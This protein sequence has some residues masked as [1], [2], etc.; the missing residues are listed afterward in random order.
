MPRR[1][2]FRPRVG[3]KVIRDGGEVMTRT[4]TATLVLLTAGFSAGRGEGPGPNN[5][6]PPPPQFP[7][8][9][10]TLSDAQ[11]KAQPAPAARVARP[12]EEA[13]TPGSVPSL[14]HPENITKFDPLAVELKY[15]D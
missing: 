2:P 5:K 10:A 6:F 3:K 13:P 12:R 14:P 9:P 15:D 7:P 1:P 11:S 4:L 8:S